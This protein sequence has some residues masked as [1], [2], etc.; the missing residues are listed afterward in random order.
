[1]CGRF[2]AKL[3]A[4]G[5]QRFFVI[6]QVLRCFLISSLRWIM[7]DILAEDIS[8]K[9]CPVRARIGQVQVP[10]LVYRIRRCNAGCGDGAQEKEFLVLCYYF[11]RICF[12][13]SI[14]PCEA[15]RKIED[16][17]LLIRREFGELLP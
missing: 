7:L 15:V 17:S 16:L 8:A 1:M 14:V 6:V 3:F 5:R 13:P 9:V 2:L 12:G 4:V 10:G 11:E